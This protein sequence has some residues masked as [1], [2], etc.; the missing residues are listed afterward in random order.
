MANE[1]VA[2]DRAIRRRKPEPVEVPARKKTTKKRAWR[3][4]EAPFVTPQMVRMLGTCQ[5]EEFLSLFPNG[6]RATAENLRKFH[7]KTGYDARYVG[8]HLIDP[9]LGLEF[10]RALR[11]GAFETVEKFLRE[12]GL[13]KQVDDIL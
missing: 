13:R 9:N 10:D 3:K 5:T 11:D 4:G 1:M 7:V 12:H 8:V 6:A 2:T